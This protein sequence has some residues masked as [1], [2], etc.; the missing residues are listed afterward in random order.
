MARNLHFYFKSRRGS[1]RHSKLLLKILRE[2]VTPALG[3]TEPIAVALVVAKAKECIC[4]RVDRIE[5][6]VDRNIFKNAMGVGIPGTDKKGLHMAVALALVGG[7]SEYRLE[8]LK[9][10][11]PQD[12]AKAQQIIDKNII[13][14][15]IVDDISGLYVEATAFSQQ[16]KV[17]VVIKDKHDNIVLVEKNGDIIFKKDG[18]LRENLMLV[19][20]VK[21]LQVKDLIEFVDKVDLKCLN[22]VIDGIK[23][24]KKIAEAGMHSRY[25]LALSRGIK[26]DAMEDREYV[27]LLTSSA[28]YARM[29][30]YPLP[31]MS[32]AGSGNQ[33]IT[34]ILPVVAVGERRQVSED[35]LIRAVTL[36]LLVTI[37][38]KSYTGI[39]APVCGCGV[40][41]GVGASVGIVYLLDGTLEQMQGAIKNMIG[42][43]AGII[44]DGGKPGCAFKLSIS[45]DA[46][47]ESAMMA[48]KGIVISSEDGIVGDTA[49][50]TIQNLGKVSTD[51][52]A[53]TDEA[54]LRIMLAKC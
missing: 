40:A 3:C 47:V 10:I 19:D 45:A 52:M 2:Q 46:A 35:K 33:G 17:T 28:C 20:D 53:K 30:G 51:G 54:I 23:M 5:I 31:V 34:A 6:K 24:N 9:D 32:C 42:T 43:L 21:K 41:A 50:K 22:F 13:D 1:M 38:V 16:E 39:L 27:K 26:V 14:V 15:N 49:E 37:Y 44:C 8:V 48:L 29:S 36:S 7:K 12:V 18:F 4:G 25:G 11:T